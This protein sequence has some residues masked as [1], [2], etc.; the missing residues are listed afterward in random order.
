MNGV[1]PLSVCVC[2]Y[3]HFGAGVCTHTERLEDNIACCSQE[4]PTWLFENVSLL[5]EYTHW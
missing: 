4:L 2:R 1:F 3:V 5:G